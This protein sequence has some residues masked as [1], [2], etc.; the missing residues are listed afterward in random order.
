[1]RWADCVKG[2]R[3]FL[4]LLHS[5]QIG[6]H[7]RRAFGVDLSGLLRIAGKQQHLACFKLVSG[8]EQTVFLIKNGQIPR[9]M[10]VEHDHAERTAV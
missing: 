4:Q 7:R 1:M 8:K 3:V 10:T 5:V 6:F 9:R 2:I